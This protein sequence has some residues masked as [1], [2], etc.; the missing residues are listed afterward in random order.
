MDKMAMEKKILT[1][2]S[3]VNQYELLT[4]EQSKQGVTEE[5]MILAFQA[6]DELVPQLGV[7][8]RI[9]QKLRDDFFAAVY[10]DELTS[11]ENKDEKEEE[12]IQRIPYFVLVKRVYSE[13]HETGEELKEQLDVVK[14]RLFDKHKQ[15]EESQKEV[16]ELHQQITELNQ[17]IKELEKV[18][19]NREKEIVRLQGVLQA[20]VAKAADKQHH[21]DCTILELKD[22]VAEATAQ[23]EFLSKFKKGY[24]D[25]Y[26]AFV[27]YPEDEYGEPKQKMKAVVSTKRANLISNIKNCQKLEEQILTVMNITLEEF[28]QSL[29]SHKAE[30]EEKVMHDDITETEIEIQEIEIDQAD[31]QLQEVQERFKHTVGDLMTEL[32]LLRQHNTMLMEQLQT[33]EENRPSI[34]TKK[35]SKKNSAKQDSILSVG[36]GDDDDDDDAMVD[37]FIPQ[38]RVFSK[39]A[40]MAY[41][42]NNQ[43]K[44]FDEFKDAK[45]CP[46]CGEKTVICPHKLGGSKKIIVLPHNCSHIKF[47]RPMVRINK[48][49]LKG[50][51]K[52][53]SPDNSVDLMHDSMVDSEASNGYSP[54]QQDTTPTPRTIGGSMSLGASEASLVHNMQ[55]LWDDY[56]HRTNLE[57]MI[58]RHLSLK[59]TLSMI[60]Q[61]LAFLVNQ[62]EYGEDEEG[63]FS[64]LDNL[65]RFLTERYLV[66]EI[67]Y[68]AAHDFLSAIIE[69]ATSH[70]LIQLL[71]HVL[72]GNMDAS[73][74]RYILMMADFM[75]DIDWKEVEDFRAFASAVYPFLGE[76]DLESLQMS[77]Q[78]F[79]ENRISALLVFNY[80]IHIILK[81]REPRFLELENK[82][83]PFQNQRPGYLTER[84]YKDALDNFLP[85][86]NEK[87]QR[88]LYLESEK[89]SNAEGEEGI[90]ITRVAQ[91]SGFLALSQIT[92]IIKDNV[93]VRIAEWRER[94]SSTD[95]VKPSGELKPVS[96]SSDDRLITMHEI[97]ILASNISREVKHRQQRLLTE[98]ES[99]W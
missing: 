9:F 82:I 26:N 19:A 5:R 73:C 52:P 93:F 35:E 7:F 54:M 60:E 63:Y 33:L 75:K 16:S 22:D 13:R 11:S 84:E 18:V 48:E 29:E 69:F 36:L 95:L 23:I 65:Y 3:P 83:V 24:D 80:I 53:L 20:T 85:L 17:Q 67:I 81:Y 32:E 74:L 97:K 47:T 88:R 21:L 58:P 70:K 90:S 96:H 14:E 8:S 86:C 38:E 98:S 25:L 71:S 37:P 92:N 87:L 51:L 4:L 91:I 76:D 79:S 78:S 28:E 15:L 44:T 45:Y 57:R 72:A 39:Y 55:T 31:Q 6:F 61:F 62:D 66:E 46:S 40:V 89:S 27:E 64:I 99:E 56:S 10:S 49:L 59:R 41:T 68:L 2:H 42:S 77:Y 12:Y 94:P 30:L 1:G 34:P 50:V 43:G